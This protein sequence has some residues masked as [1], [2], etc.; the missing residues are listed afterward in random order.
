MSVGYLLFK[1]FCEN[2][3]EEPVPQMS[4]YDEVRRSTCITSTQVC[5][6]PPSDIITI[7]LTD[8]SLLQC[9]GVF[10]DIACKCVIHI[11]SQC[12]HIKL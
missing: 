8:A 12:A 5:F 10:Y 3:S 1:D 2:I 6:I 11:P 7:R 4:F 9:S